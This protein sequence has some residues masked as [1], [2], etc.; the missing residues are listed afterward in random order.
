MLD[1][2]IPN[3]SGR[4]LDEEANTF[5]YLAVGQG[6]YLNEKVNNYRTD[7]ELREEP[8]EDQVELGYSDELRRSDIRATCIQFVQRDLEKFI[9]NLNKT[10]S[11]RIKAYVHTDAPQYK[12]ILR[13]LDT[14]INTIA[15]NASKIDI[16]LALHRELHQL[17]AN[18]KREG[19]KTLTQAGKLENYDEY[20]S[21]LA[22]FMERSNE[23]GTS[24]LAQHVMHRKII[25]EP[26]EEALSSK[27]KTERY[28]LE[29]A[30]HNIVFPMRSA[31][32]ET[33]YSQQNLWIID[34]RLTYHSF[35]SSDKPLNSHT[36]FYFD[37]KEAA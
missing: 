24:A 9:H 14:F 5:V 6:T 11:D 28:P 27:K 1:Q 2:Y 4:L 26:F 10:K 25:L 16:E 8:D 23:L 17:E 13:Y 15:P 36:D 29:E 20:R 33:L 34:E 18:L 32:R 19:V 37:L 21:R 7:F 31:D 35:V 30:V 12:P 3:L 22:N